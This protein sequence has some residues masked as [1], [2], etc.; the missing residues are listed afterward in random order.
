MPTNTPQK[1]YVVELDVRGY[2][3][4]GEITQLDG[5]YLVSGSRDVLIRRNNDRSKVVSRPGYTRKGAVKTVNKGIESSKGWKTSTNVKRNL[6]VYLDTV[7]VWYD[8]AWQTLKTGIANNTRFVWEPW[9]DSTEQIDVLLGVNG[10]S[11]LF[12]WSGAIAKI[13]TVT[14]DTI[15]K[16]GY[17]TNSTISFNDNGANPD[18]ITDSAGGFTAAGFAVGQEITISGSATNDGTYTIAAVTDTVITLIDDDELATEAVGSAIVIKDAAEG[19]WAQARFLTSGTRSVVINGQAFTYTGGEST[20][21]LT[22]VSPDPTSVSVSADDLC[23]QELVE[24]T[25]SD[26]TGEWDASYEATVLAIFNNHVFVGSNKSRE[27]YISKST[28]Y[29]DFGYTTPLRK[30]TEGF[31]LVLDAAPTAIVP[32]GDAVKISAGEDYWYEVRMELNNDQQGE[33]ITVK[34]LPTATGQAALNQGVVVPIKNNVAFLSF[35]PTVDTLGNVENVVTQRSLPVSDDIRDDLEA[36]DLTNASGIY[37][38]RELRFCLP[39]EGIELI[40]DLQHG[41]WQPPQYTPIA[42]YDVIDGVLCGHSNSANETYVLESGYNALGGIFEHV[43]A[44]GYANGGRDFEL[45]Q[46]DEVA[47]KLKMSPSTKVKD[48][49]YYDY[50][51]S[52]DVREFEIDGA[53]ETISFTPA[54]SA[55]LGQNPLGSEPLGSLAEEDEPLRMIRVINETGVRDCFEWQRVFRTSSQD[56]RFEILSFGVNVRLS[57]NQPVFIRR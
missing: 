22:G 25:I 17:H 32:D 49:I 29:D 47:C 8:S 13:A 9:W 27:V 28:A 34:K 39:K 54:Q 51:G 30:P 35:E 10:S 33:T 38:R 42:S 40:Y 48:Q 52:T 41:F 53:D 44:F 45:K 15:T 7:Q 26:L 12:Q 20:G 1:E 4:R 21:T 56:A 24:K 31:K 19:T 3:A 5:H 55:S 46:F 11:S 2:I 37:W 18:T 16:Q 50:G 36:Y 57:E 43:A 14:A 6:R 23:M